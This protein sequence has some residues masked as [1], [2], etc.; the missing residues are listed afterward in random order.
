MNR[1]N[2]ITPS[3]LNLSEAFK[4]VIGVGKTTFNTPGLPKG[5]DFGWSD[6]ENMWIYK[7]KNTHEYFT[8]KYLNSNLEVN[9]INSN[10][11]RCMAEYGDPVFCNELA[12]GQNERQWRERDA[13]EKREVAEAE[14]RREDDKWRRRR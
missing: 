11:K 5:S 4:K 8:S 3:K 1:L 13:A 2:S 14:A 12:A 9:N 7:N 10:Y 6:E